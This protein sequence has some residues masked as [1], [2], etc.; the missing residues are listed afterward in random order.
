[1]RRWG[2]EA[3]AQAPAAQASAALVEVAVHR[4]SVVV[5]WRIASPLTGGRIDDARPVALWVV[6]PART[7]VGEWLRQAQVRLLVAPSRSL[8]GLGKHTSS[9][10]IAAMICAGLG[11]AAGAY[12]VGGLL[13]LV[14]GGILGATAG[15]VL[16]VVFTLA[17]RRHL[18]GP[19]DDRDAEL[20]DA[21]AALHDI[22]LRCHES[23]S[24]VFSETSA[25]ARALLWAMCDPSISANRYRRLRYHA[26]TL[27]A[28][29]SDHH[30]AQAEL[31]DATSVAGA[32][33]WAAGQK[34]E[35]DELLDRVASLIDEL[36]CRSGATRDVADQISLV[37][38]KA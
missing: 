13:P 6:R 33:K 14:W 24:A 32:G 8:P 9:A 16:Q 26:F 38:R 17:A 3:A 34:L 2:I 20:A 7:A 37:R 30:H 15:Y 25:A 1:M 4:G 23:Y 21:I 10:V 36:R 29:A 19:V 35:G 28:A 12:L 18:R 11:A 5:R 27:A 22:V 31:V